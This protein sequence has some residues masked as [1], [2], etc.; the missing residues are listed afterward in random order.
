M[1]RYNAIQYFLTRKGAWHRLATLHTT[2][3]SSIQAH[4][5]RLSLHT[6]SHPGKPS[7]FRPGMLYL[8]SAESKGAFS[9]TFA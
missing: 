7:F 8:L 3:I 5:N 9:D 1:L 6:L 2:C 4:A